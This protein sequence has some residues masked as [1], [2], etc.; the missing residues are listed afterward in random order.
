MRQSELQFRDAVISDL[1]VAFDLFAEVQSLHADA[2]PLFFRQPVKDD[3]F[4]KYF[5]DLLGNPKQHLV[6]GCA[7]EQPIGCV[8]YSIHERARNVFMDKR[9]FAHIDH[10]I[11]AKGFR[12]NGY[13]SALIQHVV[14]AVGRQG[15]DRLGIDHWSFNDAA[16]ACFENAGFKLERRHMSLQIG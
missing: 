10:L 4:E 6:I 9:T 7:G 12:R 14:E 3:L 5:S 13:A 8:Q 1:D 2:L 15:I 16:A 11:V